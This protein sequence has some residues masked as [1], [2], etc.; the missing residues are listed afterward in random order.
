[1]ENLVHNVGVLLP[2]M[3]RALILEAQLD[4]DIFAHHCQL[5]PSWF[6]VRGDLMLSDNAI[7]QHLWQRSNDYHDDYTV[8]DIHNAAAQQTILQQGIPAQVKDHLETIA[9]PVII[10]HFHADQ[11]VHYFIR[12]GQWDI[13]AT[14]Q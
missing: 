13:R 4:A 1:C 3:R 14:D 12:S 6:V 8:G 7:D 11:R 5:R 10:D 2:G 9:L